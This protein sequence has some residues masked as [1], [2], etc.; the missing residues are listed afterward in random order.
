MMTEREMSEKINTL[1]EILDSD[2]GHSYA[3]GWLKGML[4]TIDIDLR[5]TKTQIKHLEETL[6]NNIRWARDYKG[7]SKVAITG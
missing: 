4:T 1:I 2:R 6:D 3:L 7:T 5:L